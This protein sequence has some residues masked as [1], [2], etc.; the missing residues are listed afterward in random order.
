MHILRQ[1]KAENILP[2][3]VCLLEFLNSK[4]EVFIKS[5]L[6]RPISVSLDQGISQK[7]WCFLSDDTSES[8]VL[9]GKWGPRAKV[10][11]LDL[12]SP[13][14][15]L[16]ILPYLVIS[17]I[18]VKH[19]IFIFPFPSD[20]FP[21]EDWY[22]FKVLWN[23]FLHSDV[24]DIFLKKRGWNSSFDVSS[25]VKLRQSY[26]GCLSIPYR[27]TGLFLYITDTNPFWLQI[28]LLNVW[29]IFSSFSG[30]FEK[31]TLIAFKLILNFWY[32]N[33]GEVRNS[34][35]NMSKRRD[36]KEVPKEA[37][38]SS[39]HSQGQGRQVFTHLSL[40]GEDVISLIQ[41]LRKIAFPG[42]S[43]AYL[44][45]T[46]TNHSIWN[47]N[48]ASLPHFL[49]PSK[50]HTWAN[51]CSL[52][53]TCDDLFQDSFILSIFLDIADFT[54][55]SPSLDIHFFIFLFNLFQIF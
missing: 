27:I 53:L 5:S 11:F 49:K 41:I 16:I 30:V 22:V 34:L 45:S 26:A 12:A 7:H 3:R 21:I 39:T 31:L 8:A 23:L 13:Y 36:E 44:H 35:P 29:L 55:S 28:L 25:P 43:S 46:Q 40:F 20:T 51:A 18:Y 4:L 33:F 19:M 14:Y 38:F 54:Y 48:F 2:V 32:S 6:M 10:I 37:F 15:G 52:S 24:N 47:P 42:S 1:F 9:L 17:P 50:V